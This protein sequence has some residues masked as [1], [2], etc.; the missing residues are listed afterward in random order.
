VFTWTGFYIGGNAGAAWRHHDDDFLFFDPARYTSIGVTVLTPTTGFCGGFF[1]DCGDRNRT[2]FTGGGQV[3]FNW[4]FGQF[5]WGV[6]GDINYLGGRRNDD[7]FGGFGGCG[8]A[9]NT[10]AFRLPT[11][12]PGVSGPA[13]IYYDATTVYTGTFGNGFTF[14]RHRDNW[15]ATIRGRGG[16]ALP[17]WFGGLGTLVYVTG[18]VAFRGDDNNDD[19]FGNTASVFGP[20]RAGTGV[21]AGTGLGGAANAQFGT[22]TYSTGT[23]CCG[24]DNH[25][26]G[27]ALGTGAELALTPNV[28]LGVE[29]LHLFFGRH[30]DGNVVVDPILSAFNN[31]TTTTFASDGGRRGD[32]DIVRAKLNFK[33][34]GLFGIF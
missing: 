13:G 4:Q 12:A 3:G 11:G 32:V 25:R 17:G 7:C 2:V 19:F 22:V 20:L 28:S 26:V 23:F 16:I 5:V 9:G 1:D 6:E 21:G 24:H 30:D 27:G 15:F 33:F 8:F 14:D 18:G 34:G 10:V 31:A 29:Y